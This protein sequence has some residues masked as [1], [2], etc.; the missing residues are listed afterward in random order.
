MLDQSMKG[1]LQGMFENLRSDFEL[2]LTIAADHP[3]KGDMVALLGDVADSA[4]RIELRV[5]DGDGIALRI[6]KGGEESAI[7]FE[8]LPTGHEFSSLLLAILNLDGQG[9]NLPDEQFAERIRGLQG[10]AEVRSYILL[11]CPNCPDVVQAMNVISIIN[12]RIRH[13]VIDGA[14]IGDEMER[15]GIQAVPTLYFGDE[16]FHVGRATL[17]DL[18]AAL[19][20][21]ML[22]EAHFEE[23]SHTF[24][25]V[26]V[27]GGP[28]GA[29]AAIYAARKGFAVALVAERVGGQ[30]LET[31]AIENITAMVKVMGAEYASLL[32]DQME[33]YPIKIFDNRRVESIERIEDRVTKLHTSLNETL[34]TRALIIATGAHWRTL[35]VEGE[36]DYI[37]RGVAFC[38]HCDAPFYEGRR[39]VV[40]GGGNS[41]IEAAMDLSNVARSVTLVEYAEEL[42]GDEMLRERMAL[43]G[44]VTVV[45]NAETMRITGDGERV[46]GVEIRDRASDEKRVL[47]TDG[48]FIQIGL[49]P[50]SEIFGDVVPLSPRGEIEVDQSCRTS[51]K[52]IY[53]AGDVTTVPYKQIVV[54][55]GEGAKAAISAFE[56][57]IAGLI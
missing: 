53:A 32:R 21:R 39:V 33:R 41:G 40:V 49:L 37:G 25:V 54:A 51:I 10:E 9:R 38:T 52:G 35:G 16:L 45:T 34:E 43:L 15:M 14:L 3:A 50:N 11:T 6:A 30:T 48:V 29:T 57:I 55:Q 23:Q 31:Q 5:E 13:R 18:V 42:T 24:D 8:C 26:V 2:R 36:S 17:G 12:P 22:S 4:P 28:A 19:E 56:D 47:E 7:S 20:G 1:Q 44:I 27:G 46:T